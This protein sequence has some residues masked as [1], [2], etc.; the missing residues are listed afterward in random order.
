MYRICAIEGA[1]LLS[2]VFK[3]QTYFSPKSDKVRIYK[4]VSWSKEGRFLCVA[5]GGPQIMEA[6]FPHL[7]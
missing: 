7:C 3:P 2:L 6:G 5:R 1:K 4:G